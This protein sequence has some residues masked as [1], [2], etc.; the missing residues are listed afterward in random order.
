M[1][2]SDKLKE[3]QGKVIEANK[4]LLLVLRAEKKDDAAS[5]VQRKVEYLERHLWAESYGR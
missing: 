5:R 2:M 4:N 3:A 1:A